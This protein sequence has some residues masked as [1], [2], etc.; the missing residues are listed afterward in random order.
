LT[1]T[2][3]ISVQDDPLPVILAGLKVMAPEVGP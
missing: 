3:A 1:M 2:F